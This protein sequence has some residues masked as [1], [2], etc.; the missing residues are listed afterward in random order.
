M[1]QP[2]VIDISLSPKSMCQEQ[3]HSVPQMQTKTTRPG[4]GGRWTPPSL[5]CC[6]LTQ[7]RLKLGAEII[8]VR[9]LAAQMTPCFTDYI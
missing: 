4:L 6:A 5:L 8:S 2:Q 9:S 7:N 3:R 1:C